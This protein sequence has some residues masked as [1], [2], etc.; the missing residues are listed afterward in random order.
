MLWLLAFDWRFW[1][2]ALVALLALY[3][4]ELIV[5]GILAI[6]AIAAFIFLLYKY[7]MAAKGEKE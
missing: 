7:A 1:F 5:L 4:G 6:L 2:G 3:S